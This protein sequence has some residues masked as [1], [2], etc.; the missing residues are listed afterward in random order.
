[1]SYSGAYELLKGLQRS[2]GLTA[3]WEGEEPVGFTR[4]GALQKSADLT[5]LFEIIVCCRNLQPLLKFSFYTIGLGE[6]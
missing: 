4:S 2:F 5:S 3:A 1:M 6:F